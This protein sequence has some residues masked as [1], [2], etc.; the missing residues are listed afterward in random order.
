LAD[1]EHHTG[2]IDIGDL[3]VTEF[4]D[5]QAGRVEGREHR[6]RFEAAR[7]QEKGGDCRLTEDGWKGLGP[8]GL[9]NV[10]EHGRLAERHV[11][12]KAQRT[13]RLHDEGP[14]D[15]AFVD[16]IELILADV[17]RTKPLWGRPKVLGKLGHTA[18]IGLDRLRGIVPQLQVF[19]HPLA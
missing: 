14:G 8:L 17:L 19:A 16:E 5:P 4:R 11:V 13:D 7:G 10:G 12:E 1:A 6:P 2:T 15:V 9:G 3:Q 18:E